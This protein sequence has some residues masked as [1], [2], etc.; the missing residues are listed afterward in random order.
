MKRGTHRARAIAAVLTETANSGRE[1]VFVKFGLVEN[2]NETIGWQ[3]YFGDN[4]DRGGK[5]LTERTVDALRVC[6]WKGD[7]LTDL[8]S[9]TAKEVEIVVQEEEY[10]GETRLKVRYVQEVGTAAKFMP[11]ALP[12]TRAARLAERIKP[13]IRGEKPKYDADPIDRDRE[14]DLRF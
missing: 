4:K 11:E 14:D 12:P 3:G 10:Q 8:S 2:M 7:D 1:L 6:G 9:V 5:T 13:R